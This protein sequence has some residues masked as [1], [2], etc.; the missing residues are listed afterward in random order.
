MKKL[1][2]ITLGEIKDA[3]EEHLLSGRPCTECPLWI[4]CMPEGTH[5]YAPT[6]WGTELEKE[7]E[8]K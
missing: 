2:E 6:C 4:F 1:G 8:V 3:C 7:V 5:D